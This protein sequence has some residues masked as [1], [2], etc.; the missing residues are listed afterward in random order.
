MTTQ[1]PLPRAELLRPKAAC[2]LLGIGR[3]KLWQLSEQ[4]P[5]FPRKI[6]LGPRCV[7]WRAEALHRYLRD[8]EAEG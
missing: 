8:V 5:R 1:S 7:G 6:V 2:A 4:D 3:T